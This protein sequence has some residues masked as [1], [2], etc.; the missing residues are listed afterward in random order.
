MGGDSRFVIGENERKLGN[1]VLCAFVS[2]LSFFPHFSRCFS[3]S[4]RAGYLRNKDPEA[5]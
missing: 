5:N 2:Y 3:T 1:A 4:T